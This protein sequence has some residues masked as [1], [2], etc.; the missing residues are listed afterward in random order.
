MNAIQTQADTIYALATPPGRGA[1]AIVRLSGPHVPDVLTALCGAVPPARHAKLA[2]ISDP[3]TG[4][5]LDHA[6][7][8]YFKGPASF[9]GEDVAELSLHGGRAVIAA[10]I[11]AVAAQPHTR[12][13]EPGEFTKRAFIHHKMDLTEAEAVADL[14]HAETAMQRRQA[15]QQ[16]GGSLHTL[17]DTWRDRLIKSCAYIEAHLDFPDED[18]PTDLVDYV[19]PALRELSAELAAH[20]GDNRRGEI[21]RDGA[22]VVILGAPNAGKS[23]LL[24]ALAARDVAIVSEHAGTT[25]DVIDVHLDLSG[26]PVILTDTAGLRPDD[27]GNSASDTIEAEGIRRAF[28]S[29]RGADLKIVLFDGLS[30]D[31]PDVH[32]L[33]LI[34]DASIV[35]INKCDRIDDV[36]AMIADHPALRISAMTGFGID[37]LMSTITARLNDLMG[38]FEG[39]SLT[40]AR[41]REA[42]AICHASIDAA[43]GI[44]DIVLLAEELR[45]AINALGRIT[46]RVDVED[47]LD[48]IFRDFCIG[49]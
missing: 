3:A 32:S 36:P 30:L 7:V 47:L 46:G 1:L 2:K 37:E 43:L 16:L 17:Y 26:Y 8:T 10:V 21:L 45:Y 49:K 44:G 42:I 27:L 15:L 18:L 12:Q 33:A 4:D 25:R 29:A 40:R 20:L 22:R 41:H 14:I 28:E 34:D 31:E 13:A 19:R 48:I 5:I 6:V 23:S 11:A 35:V 39:A 9:T 24:N 38:G